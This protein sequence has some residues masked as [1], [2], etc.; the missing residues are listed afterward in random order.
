MNN[1]TILIVFLIVGFILFGTFWTIRE[2]KR[3]EMLKQKAQSLG[4]TFLPSVDPGQV[5]LDSSFQL[6]S[7][8]RRK[9]IRNLMQKQSDGVSTSIFDYI[10]EMIRCFRLNKEGNNENSR[11]KSESYL[12]SFQQETVFKNRD[13]GRIGTR[14]SG[15]LGQE[16]G[17][18]KTIRADQNKY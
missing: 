15:N 5:Q 2:K 3:Q 10:S 8:G 1:E 6:F 18:R 9:R 14:N 7:R 12:Q 17:F 16:P 4:F 13:H 11:L